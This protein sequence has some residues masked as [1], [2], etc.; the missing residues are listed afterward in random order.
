ME[1]YFNLASRG[2]E[3][4]AV[5]ASN[6]QVRFEDYLNARLFPKSRC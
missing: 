2:R 5:P 4:K 3:A 6:E 1:H